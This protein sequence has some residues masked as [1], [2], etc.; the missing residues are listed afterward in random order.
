VVRL[1]LAGDDGRPK[2]TRFLRDSAALRAFILTLLILTPLLTHYCS[3]MWQ[4]T[5]Y[6]YF[7]FTRTF[8]TP[9]R[10]RVHRL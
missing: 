2:H 3:I 4:V 6:W 1:L 10:S 9:I 8:N 5:T 7:S